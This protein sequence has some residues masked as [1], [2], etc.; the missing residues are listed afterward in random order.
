MADTLWNPS[1]FPY[2]LIFYFMSLLLSGAESQQQISASSTPGSPDDLNKSFHHFLLGGMHTNPDGMTALH[3]H[4]HPLSPLSAAHPLALQHPQ[5]HPPLMMPTQINPLEHPLH[6]HPHLP[7]LHPAIPPPP[8]APP[9]PAHAGPQPTALLLPQHLPPVLPQSFVLPA[10]QVTQPK[11]FAAVVD[12]LDSNVVK[13]EYVNGKSGSDADLLLRA[14]ASDPTKPKVPSIGAESV[15]ATTTILPTTSKASTLMKRV[16]VTLEAQANSTSP[17]PS[18]A[19]ERQ[20][21]TRP[22]PTTSRAPSGGILVSGASRTSNVC[23]P[24]SLG[25]G[26][27][28]RYQMHHFRHSQMRKSWVVTASPPRIWSPSCNRRT[29]PPTTHRC[30]SA[31]WIGF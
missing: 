1:R 6:S 31:W 16:E 18:A 8:V 23:M 5:H 17:T 14:S 13:S 19:T 10:T 21:T 9:H 28:S 12:G 11:A 20:P 7:A 30:S 2:P 22:S 15:N 29:C 24:C 26:D 25:C 27:D 3:H 4:H